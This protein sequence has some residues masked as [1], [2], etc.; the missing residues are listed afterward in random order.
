MECSEKKWHRN[1]SEEKRKLD[2]SREKPGG[3]EALEVR[4]LE[5]MSRWPLWVCF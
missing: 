5:Q 2:K 1:V 3:R 4:K